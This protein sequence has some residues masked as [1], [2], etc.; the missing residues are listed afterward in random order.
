MKKL[1]NGYTLAEEI[2]HV[3]THGAGAILSIG[4]LSWMLYLSI[5]ASD[6]WRIAASVVYGLSLVVLF[7]FIVAQDC[8]LAFFQ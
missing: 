4:G 6:P 8:M 3:L 5:S 7:T 2:V 1:G